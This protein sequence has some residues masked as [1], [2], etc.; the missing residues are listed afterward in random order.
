ML[1][2]LAMSLAYLSGEEEGGGGVF[3]SFKKNYFYL[4]SALRGRDGGQ[5]PV[6]SR[7]VSDRE[8][9]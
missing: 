8:I 2:G 7:Q 3:Y 5:R 1:Y 9:I 4:L 6:V